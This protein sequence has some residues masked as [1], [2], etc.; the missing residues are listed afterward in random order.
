MLRDSDAALIIGDPAMTFA[1]DGLRV[2]D[3]AAL[4]HD[5]TGLGF[6]FAMWMAAAANGDTPVIDFVQAAHEG[7]A[8][9]KEIIDHYEQRLDLSRNELETYLMENIAFFLDDDLRKGLELYYELA[10]KHQ[11]IPGLKPLNL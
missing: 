8:Q 6:V 9:Q 1:R 10:Y 3:L 5:F 11:L 2:W 4:W 7:L